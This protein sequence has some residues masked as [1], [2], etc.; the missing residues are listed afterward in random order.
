MLFRSL[1]LRGQANWTAHQVNVA[2]SPEAL[3]TAVM[4]RYWMIA[5]VD[6]MIRNQLLEARQ[7][8]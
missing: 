6:Q 1:S 7:I 8:K 3:T 4:Q 5:Y 2:L